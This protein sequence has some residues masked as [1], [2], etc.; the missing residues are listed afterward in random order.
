MKMKVLKENVYLVKLDKRSGKTFEHFQHRIDIHSATS[1]IQFLYWL[2]TNLGLGLPWNLYYSVQHRLDFDIPR[3][4]VR[5]NEPGKAFTQVF[6][7]S[8]LVP[9]I[10]L[11]HGD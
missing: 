6:V 2:Q 7:R 10:L 8:D 11:T 9:F 3:W 5:Y 1:A 4:T